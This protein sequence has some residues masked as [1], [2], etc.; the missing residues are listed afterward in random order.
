MMSSLKGRILASVL[1]ILGAG[2]WRW[3]PSQRQSLIA[4]KPRLL[5]ISDQVF[6]GSSRVW[7][8]ST[9]EGI[10]F[11]YAL[12]P[13]WTHPWAGINMAFGDSAARAMDLRQWDQLEVRARSVPA[14]ALRIQLLSDDL[15]PGKEFRDSIHPIY[16]VL[17]YVPDGSVT[18]FP[19]AAFS[20]PSW[21]RAQNGRT[22][23]Q[24]LELLDRF[25]AIEFH[26][27]DSPT[28]NDSALVEISALDL[29]RPDPRF[30]WG[31]R[32]LLAFGF[33]L[34]ALGFLKK[35]P[36][37]TV[38]KGAVVDLVGE[39]VTMD[40]PRSRQSAKLVQDLRERFSDPNLSL[41]SF[42]Q[43]QGMPPRLVASLLKEATLLHFKGALNELRLT[44]AARLLRESQANISEIAFAVGFQNLSHFGRAFR[45]KFGVSPSEFRAGKSSP[46]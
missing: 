43:T 15:R 21:W 37:P 39:P 7:L 4:K 18:S 27:G 3:A 25:R 19:W 38:E 16:H 17:E 32:V 23:V 28:G 45:E 9:R 36:R 1:V 42:A 5:T 10:Q 2:L 29:V 40:N 6:G 44:E 24:R 22:D 30:V 33:A 11:R 12:S 46:G 13:V 34:L 14:R 20:V 31:G 8:E 35:R 41:E 26:S